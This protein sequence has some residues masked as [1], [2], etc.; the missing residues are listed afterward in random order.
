MY[1]A[2]KDGPWDSTHQLGVGAVC[3]ILE[4]G[5]TTVSEEYAAVGRIVRISR[6]SLHK[7]NIGCLFDELLKDLALR[8]GVGNIEVVHQVEERSVSSALDWAVDMKPKGLVIDSRNDILRT[9][10]FIE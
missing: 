3:L 5:V 2:F 9:D 1:V 4:P 6:R 10:R 7:H 8:V